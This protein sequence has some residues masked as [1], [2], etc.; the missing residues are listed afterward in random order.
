MHNPFVVYS[1]DFFMRDL[2]G[3]L[4]AQVCPHDSS[5]SFQ[6]LQPFK[7]LSF[8]PIPH[9]SNLIQF[10]CMLLVSISSLKLFPS[11]PVLNCCLCVSNQFPDDSFLDRSEGPMDYHAW[12]CIL[13]VL[14]SECFTFCSKRLCFGHNIPVRLRL[15]PKL[16]A[17]KD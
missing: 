8:M 14:Y 12:L 11:C 2:Q 3:K 7:P 16:E 10:L 5:E 9:E 13:S 15:C 1:P 6:L 4:G 17:S